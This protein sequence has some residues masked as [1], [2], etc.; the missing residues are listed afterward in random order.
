MPPP[1]APGRLG[2]L[3]WRREG[4][5][6]PVPSDAEQQLRQSH[7]RRGERRVRLQPQNLAPE[8][9]ATRRHGEGRHPTQGAAGLAEVRH[10]QTS[11]PLA[12]HR[13]SLL[14]SFWLLHVPVL[15]TRFTSEG[16]RRTACIVHRNDSSVNSTLIE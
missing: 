3:P 12:A 16:R 10:V 13:V 2:G 9:G 1:G 5:R 6:D 14:V 11:G 4:R 8:D 15:F 7:G